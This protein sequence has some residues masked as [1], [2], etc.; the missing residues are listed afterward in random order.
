VVD[1]LEGLGLTRNLKAF[2]ELRD[3]KDIMELRQ[4][5][6]QLQLVGHLSAAL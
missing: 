3:M 6:G 1:L 4:L 5:C 2:A